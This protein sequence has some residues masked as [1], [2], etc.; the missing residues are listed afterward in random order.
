MVM[1]DHTPTD[2]EAEIDFGTAKYDFYWLIYNMR[3]SYPESSI[4]LALAD[5]KACFRFPRIHPDLTGAFGFLINSLY[6]LAVAMVFGSN[7]SSSSW[8]PF[9]RAIEG[10]TKKIANRPD[11][12]VKHKTY[13]DMIKWDLPKHNAPKP[14]LARKCKLNPGVLDSSGANINHPTRIWVDDAL[15]AA[16]ELTAMKMALAAVIEAIFV[17][18]GQPDLTLRQCPL[19]MDKWKKLVV[20]EKQ[21]ALGLIL[22]TREMTVCITH[23]YL[24]STLH[25]IKTNW[26]NS[27]KTIFRIGSIKNGRQ[28]CQIDRR[29]TLGPLLA[30]TIVLFY[31]ICF[32]TKQAHAV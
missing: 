19:A 13:I 3:V 18:M 29:C 4:L 20:G 2:D 32:G 28:A 12:V 5:I 8:E 7:T 11:L 23:E 1:N 21:L 6:C 9:R 31:C 30:F 27:K 26:P 15:I 22:K 25:L 10:L 14:V 17:V 24:C 16:V